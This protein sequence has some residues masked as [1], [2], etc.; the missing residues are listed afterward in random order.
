MTP[1]G[2]SLRQTWDAM[3]NGES[4]AGSISSLDLGA[5]EYDFRTTVA[6][7]VD[8]EPAERDSVDERS[9]GRHSQLGVIAA[10]EAMSD[11]GFP[12]EPN[13]DDP[14]KVGVSFAS[15]I[16]G[17]LEIEE[18]VTKLRE[19]GSAATR[20]SIQLLPN[21]TAGHVSI[22]FDA[23]GPNRAPS[24]ACAAGTHALCDAVDDIRLG[25]ADVMIVGGADAGVCVTVL[26]SF[27]VLRAMSTRNERPEAAI[28]PFDA[29]RDGFLLGEGA[30]ALVLESAE[31][32]AERGASVYAAI[33]GV[34]RS[35]DAEHPVRPATD[36]RGLKAAVQEALADAERTPDAVDH[37]NAHATATPRGDE[38]EALC[39]NETFDEVPPVTGTKSMIGHTLG[40][41]GA[42]EAAVATLS[43]EEGV[44]PPTCNYETPDPDC[45]VPVV[46]ETT[47]ADVETVLSTSAGF[48]GT[49]GTVIISAH[50]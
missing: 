12:L 47:G 19:E 30:G 42:I 33:E 3:T 1:V 50:D 41:S 44:I 40:A 15:C 28:R 37:V 23:R 24:T 22:M 27:D 32:A 21:L 31:H 10:R 11:G 35:A 8:I 43:I 46:G 7:E 18:N 39:L 2:E 13:W 48:G 4:G 9:M 6:C 16:G 26:G 14:E 36:A 49:N 45:D 5:Y 20:F 25:R 38:H 34:G 29:E 17:H